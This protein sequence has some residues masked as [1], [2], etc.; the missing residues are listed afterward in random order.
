MRS[1][2]TLPHASAK[3]QKGWSTPEL[4]ASAAVVED[5]VNV[6]GQVVVVVFPS[7]GGGH[8]GAVLGGDNGRNAEELGIEVT[9]AIEHSSAQQNLSFGVYI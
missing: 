5:N 2:Q 7:V 3:S 8:K 4:P 1:R 6:L 9:G